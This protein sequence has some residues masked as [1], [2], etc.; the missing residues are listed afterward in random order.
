MRKI[1]MAAI[2]VLGTLSTA[3]A[4]DEKNLPELPPPPSAKQQE[5]PVARGP[6]DAATCKAPMKWGE[7][8]CY[9]GKACPMKDGS[10]GYQAY[11][12]GQLGCSRHPPQYTAEMREQIAGDPSMAE[13][14]CKKVSGWWS[15]DRC[16]TGKKCDRRDGSKGYEAMKDGVLGCSQ[17]GPQ[18]GL[19]Q[20]QTGPRRQNMKTGHAI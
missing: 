6:V 9:T 5:V 13:A 3:F 8:R 2:V 7:D 14:I 1:L 20:Q 17:F 16:F 4:Q 11:K 15:M 19:P 12:D 10:Q 18:K